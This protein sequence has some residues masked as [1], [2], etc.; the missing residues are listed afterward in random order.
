MT[1]SNGDPLTRKRGA[2]LGGHPNFSL[3]TQDL[4]TQ[5]RRLA[6]FSNEPIP[7][8][9]RGF[10]CLPLR[11]THRSLLAWSKSLVASTPRE[12]VLALRMAPE[13]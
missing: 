4:Q 1:Y 12:H 5:I 9:W 11:R 13:Y 7:Y 10:S 2:S 6:Y 3:P 8:D